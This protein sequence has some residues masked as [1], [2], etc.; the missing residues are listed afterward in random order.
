MCDS[1]E[2]PSAEADRPRSQDRQSSIATDD[3]GYREIED[4]NVVRALLARLPERQR[5]IVELRFFDQMSQAE[6][7]ATVGISQMHV[8]RLLQRSFE[9]MRELLRDDESTGD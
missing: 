5:E 8:S 6:I 2:T 1:I 4:A 9:Q 3:S 7:A